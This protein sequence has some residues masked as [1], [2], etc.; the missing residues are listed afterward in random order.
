MFT[1]ESHQL[2]LVADDDTHV[3]QLL[4]ITLRTAGFHVLGA[5]NGHELVQLAQQHVPNLILTDLLM[6]QMDGYEAIRQLRGDTRTAHIPMLILT[7]RTRSND[8]VTGFET[9]A[10]DYIV[11][12]FDLTELLV[13]IKS[14]LR[15]TARPSVHHPLSGLPGSR[16]LTQELR[17]RIEQH[18]PLALLHIDIDNFKTFN[19]TYGFARGDQL[20]LLV[21]RLL[22]DVLAADPT[23]DDFVGHI[24]GDDFA[25]I[26]T[27]ERA[28]AVCQN[29]VLQFDER[30]KQLYP[31]EDWQRG[32]VFGTD[33]YGILRRFPVTAISIG[34]ATNQARQFLDEEE[35]AHVAAEVKHYAKLQPGSSYAINQRVEQ[36][37]TD[38][39]RRLM[40]LR[41]ILLISEDMSLRTVLGQ[42]F[43][44]QGYVTHDVPDP[45]H[46]PQLLTSQAASLFLVVDA[47]LGHRAEELCAMCRDMKPTPPVVV[48]TYSSEQTAHFRQCG[49]TACLQEPL[50]LADVVTC[51][52]RLMI[53]AHVWKHN[54]F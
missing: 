18:A 41:D 23:S 35:F 28:E 40:R 8:L 39:E 21:A 52:E 49:A 20:I 30:V 50:P 51:V 1:A 11:K 29:I 3:R 32:Y 54:V 16:L 6:P 22:Q 17:R 47:H 42:A 25:V 45:Q 33:R 34:V 48:L 10:D 37:E 2:I 53:H 19:D 7:A 5:S 24:G 26:T 9:G 12:P 46:I 27:P 44:K 38:V 31:A 36:A 14:H 43:R 15:R 4:E 13:R